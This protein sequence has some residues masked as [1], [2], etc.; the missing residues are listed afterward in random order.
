MD[1]GMLSQ[2]EAEFLREALPHRNQLYGYAQRMT[3]NAEDAEDLIQE[4]YLKAYKFWDHY[5]TGTNIRAW[6]FRILRNSLINEYRKK[7]HQPETVNYEAGRDKYSHDE[8]VEPR[9]PKPDPFS[10]LL[11]D[12]VE[13]AIASLPHD[14]RTVAILCDIEGFSYRDIAKFTQCPIGTVRSRLHRARR[15]LHQ[16]LREYARS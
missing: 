4:T 8:S 2:K 16:S 12:E 15:L 14:F 5:E 13:N 10:H 3:Q 11:G 6:M 9:D 7:S 1:E